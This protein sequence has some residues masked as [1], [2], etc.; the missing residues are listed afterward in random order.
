VGKVT[1]DR[2]QENLG[3][4]AASL[5]DDISSEDVEMNIRCKKLA[6]ELFSSEAAVKQVLKTLNSVK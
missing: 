4:L 3:V 2:N 5:I 1:T 6:A